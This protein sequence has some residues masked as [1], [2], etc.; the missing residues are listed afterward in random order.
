[1]T[2]S[3]HHIV[4]IMVVALSAFK[5]QAQV[6]TTSKS[7]EQVDE[8]INQNIELISEQL[9]AEEGDL[10][11][12]TDSWLYY[13]KHPINLNKATKDELLDLQLLSDIQINNL[14]KHRQK[15]CNLIV[16]YELQSID[17]FDLVTIKK[18]NKKSSHCREQ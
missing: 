1:M 17:G 5:L 2:F 7:N 3:K 6:D 13:K 14:L 15:N 8:Q 12:L 16:I 11:N 18:N 10:S 9:Q 4:I